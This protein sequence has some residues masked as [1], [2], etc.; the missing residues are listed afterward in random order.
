MSFLKGAVQAS[1]LPRLSTTTIQGP[2]SAWQP[3]VT[4]EVSS[5]QPC[6]QNL[7]TASPATQKKCRAPRKAQGILHDLICHDPSSPSHSVL[8]TVLASLLFWH[9]PDTVCQVHAQVS[10]SP[11]PSHPP[12]L[13]AE[14]TFSLNSVLSPHVNLNLP[15]PANVHSTLPDLFFSLASAKL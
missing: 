4:A 3:R 13:D 12:A 7:P 15:S 2:F 8:A 11:L 5:C 14:V 9:I 6:A 10:A 1:L